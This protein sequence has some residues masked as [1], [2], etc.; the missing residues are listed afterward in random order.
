ASVGPDQSSCI[1]GIKRPDITNKFPAKTIPPVADLIA[2]DYVNR[3]ANLQNP[4]IVVLVD[5]LVQFDWNV[6]I[7]HL[8]GI[9]ARAN[10]SRPLLN[11]EMISGPMRRVATT[12]AL[13]NIGIR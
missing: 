4:A 9:I 7:S 8:N 10:K 11:V 5:P 1:S 6:Q 13:W 12:G 3:T 2:N